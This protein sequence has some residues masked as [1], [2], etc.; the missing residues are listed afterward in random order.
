[1]KPYEI[2][3]GVKIR[4]KEG[5]FEYFF[6][7]DSIIVTTDETDFNKTYSGVIKEVDETGVYLED[8]ERIPFE[9]IVDIEKC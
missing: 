1:M 5:E 8:V 9:Y 7:G 2:T 6:N 3:V 4:N